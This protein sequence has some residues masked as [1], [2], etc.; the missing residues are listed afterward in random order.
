MTNTGNFVTVPQV[1]FLTFPPSPLYFCSAFQ[2][3]GFFFLFFFQFTDFFLC[4]SF[5]LLLRSSLTFLFQY[6]Y[7]SFGIWPLRAELLVLKIPSELFMGTLHVEFS[8]KTTNY[9]QDC[10]ISTQ[11]LSKLHANV[12]LSSIP[13]IQKT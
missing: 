9:L 7:Q 4:L 8:Q 13:F 3:Q 1:S 6:P 12:S 11:S 2:I 5:I 10:L